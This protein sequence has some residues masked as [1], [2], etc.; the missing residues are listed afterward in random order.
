MKVRTVLNNS[1][2][3]G[4]YCLLHNFFGEEGG[5]VSVSR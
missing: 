2:I 4:V 5:L 3:Y 1:N